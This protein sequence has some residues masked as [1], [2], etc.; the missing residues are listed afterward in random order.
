MPLSDGVPTFTL[1]AAFPPLASDGVE[2]S[3]TLTFTPVPNLLA[4]AS[5]LY[6]GVENATLDATGGMSK[7]LIACDALDEPF[8]WRVDGQIDGMPPFSVNISVPASAGTVNLGAVAEFEALP[9]DYVVVL[10]P[11]GP[12]GPTGNGTPSSTVADGTAFGESSAAG[13]ASAYSRGD[14]SHG[15][16][17]MPRLDQAGSPTSDVAMGGHKV[18]GLANGTVATDAAAFGQIPTVGSGATNYVAGNDS[19]LTDNRTPSGSAGGDLSGSYPNPSVVKLNGITI[20]GTPT[21]GQ[22]LTA[23]STTTAT[24]QDPTSGGGATALPRVD[25]NTE[26]PAGIIHLPGPAAD[27]TPVVGAGSVAVARD[28]TG[29][30]AGDVIELNAS[31][32]RIGT[33]MQLDAR[34]VVDGTPARYISAAAATPTVS[35]DEGEPAWYAGASYKE[36]TSTRSF[37]L[38]AGD[39]AADGALRIELVY[40]GN[41]IPADNSHTLYF[42]SGYFGHFDVVHWKI[43]TR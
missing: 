39:V 41:S 38:Q 18:T 43:G 30:V 3:G 1:V 17:A 35:G 7:T 24:W 21:A 11:Q 5:H 19:R 42:G 2:R 12:E 28:I 20:T 25:Y 8:V 6:T 13:V 34:F 26:I 29:A 23:T 22:V 33:S 32:L 16:P 27:W 15:T 14:H 40:R 9:T 37:I 10:G 31:F 4:D 36:A